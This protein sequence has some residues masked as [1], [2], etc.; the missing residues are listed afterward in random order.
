MVIKCFGSGWLLLEVR[1]QRE[2][3][4]GIFTSEKPKEY[5]LSKQDS[6]LTLWLQTE[7]SSGRPALF[8]PT[9]VPRP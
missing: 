8:V 2:L 1:L 5:R 3:I 4:M 6:P 7:G 9:S